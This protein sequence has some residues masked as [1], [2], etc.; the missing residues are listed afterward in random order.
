MEM[1][2]W[3]T[4]A[5]SQTMPGH[6]RGA[7]SG[8]DDVDDSV[9]QCGISLRKPNC[10]EVDYRKLHLPQLLWHSESG[11]SHIVNHLTACS[12]SETSLALCYQ[13]AMIYPSSWQAQGQG[14]QGAADSVRA[15]DAVFSLAFFA[16]IQ[17]Y[18]CLVD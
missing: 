11:L 15:G 2:W 10:L 8:W 14:W 13:T 17:L 9:P 1:F 12:S 5:F 4:A 3:L 18:I 6:T 16:G 7:G